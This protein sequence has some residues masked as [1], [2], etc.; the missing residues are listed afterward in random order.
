MRHLTEAGEEKE[1]VLKQLAE[2]RGRYNLTV[3]LSQTVNFPGTAQCSDPYLFLGFIPL[4][5]SGEERI[6]TTQ[7]YEANGHRVTFTQC[8]STPSSH[9]VISK[10]PKSGTAMCFKARIDI[11]FAH[12]SN[13]LEDKMKAVMYFRVFEIAFGGSGTYLSSRC[14]DDTDGV[15]ALTFGLPLKL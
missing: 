5:F 7:G 10:S 6:Q 15:V 13:I 11:R 4:S 8:D 3:M 12:F 1:T 2:Y 14:L 9:I